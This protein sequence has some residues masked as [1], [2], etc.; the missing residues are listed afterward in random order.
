MWGTVLETLL[1]SGWTHACTSRSK[2]PCNHV[3]FNLFPKGL[4]TSVSCI[5]L[6]VALWQEVWTANRP[7]QGQRHGWH[8]GFCT[9]GASGAQ[10]MDGSEESTNLSSARPIVMGAGCEPWLINGAHIPFKYDASSFFV[11]CLPLR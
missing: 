7:S 11:V 4:F 1:K 3:T 5:P 6:P 2:D 10:G 9:I 8:R